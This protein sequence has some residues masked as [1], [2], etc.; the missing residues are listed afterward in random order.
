MHPNLVILKNE[1]G[2]CLK[3]NSESNE[4]LESKILGEFYLQTDDGYIEASKQWSYGGIR[5]T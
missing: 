2:E 5:K 3:I 1:E 4:I